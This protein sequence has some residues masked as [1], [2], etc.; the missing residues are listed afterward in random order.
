VA[1]GIHPDLRRGQIIAQSRGSGNSVP[2]QLARIVHGTGRAPQLA[3]RE[4]EYKQRALDKPKH[5]ANR[6]SRPLVQHSL[7]RRSD[8]KR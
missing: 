5:N 6:V 8:A 2:K 1:N 4:S 3:H 7:R